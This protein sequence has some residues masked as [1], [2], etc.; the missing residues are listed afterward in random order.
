VDTGE[1]RR[2]ATTGKTRPAQPL[3]GLFLAQFLGSFNDNAWNPVIHN[4]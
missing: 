3:R 4:S 2:Q 1:H